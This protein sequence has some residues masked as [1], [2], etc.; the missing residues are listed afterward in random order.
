MKL[1]EFGSDVPSNRAD[2]VYYAIKNAKSVG[3][4]NENGNAVVR[5]DDARADVIVPEKSIVHGF[6]RRMSTQAPVMIKIGEV[7]NAI[8]V[9]ELNQKSENI[10]NTYALIG[11]AINENNE[12]YIANFIVNRFSNEVTEVDVLYSA[13][14]KKNRLHFCRSLRIK[15]LLLPILLLVY[16]VC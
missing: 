9:N 5:V 1:T 12:L 8:K 3:Y 6:D 2:I 13:D 7:K 15:P 14:A 4:T 16:Q 11:S 10:K